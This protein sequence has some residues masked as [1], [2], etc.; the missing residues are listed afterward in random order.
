[1]APDAARGQL[2]LAMGGPLQQLVRRHS[3]YSVLNRIGRHTAARQAE[4]LPA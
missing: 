3:N 1:M 4:P 2:K